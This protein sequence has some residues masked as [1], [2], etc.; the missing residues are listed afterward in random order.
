MSV[1]KSNLHVSHRHF[2]VEVAGNH[3][4]GSP[5]SPTLVLRSSGEEKVVDID[6][7]QQGQEHEEQAYKDV[8]INGFDTG[9]VGELIPHM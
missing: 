7:L 9:N 8:D 4:A 3:S 6:I 1:K 2:L 5:M